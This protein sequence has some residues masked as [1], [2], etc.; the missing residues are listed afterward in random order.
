MDEPEVVNQSVEANSTVVVKNWRY[1]GRN[2][3]TALKNNWRYYGKKA[4][5]ILKWTAVFFFASTLF[6]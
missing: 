4:L 5:I 2:A 6:S 3:L 1:Y